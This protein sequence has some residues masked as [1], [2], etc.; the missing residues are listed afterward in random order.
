MVGM[1]TLRLAFRARKGSVVG[2]IP[3]RHSKREWERWCWRE[4]APS[5]VSSEGGPGGVCGGCDSPLPL[6]TRVGGAGYY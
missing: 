3:L 4:N 1:K 5:R 2:A 6:E